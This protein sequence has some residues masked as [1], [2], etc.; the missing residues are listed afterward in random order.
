[1]SARNKS[2]SDFI[3]LDLRPS[4]SYHPDYMSYCKSMS[5]EQD[6]SITRFIQNLIYN[7]MKAKGVIT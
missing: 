6:I 2:N 4:R 7:D 5:E 1:M 3:R